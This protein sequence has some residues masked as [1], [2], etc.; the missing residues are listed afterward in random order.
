[1][2]VVV[3][4]HLKEEVL[5]LLEVFRHPRLFI[6]PAASCEKKNIIKDIGAFSSAIDNSTVFLNRGK[7]AYYVNEN[8]R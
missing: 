8:G 5:V 2:V 4:T 7:V 1:M 3:G 6:L